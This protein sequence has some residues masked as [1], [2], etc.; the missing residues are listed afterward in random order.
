[1]TRFEK[2]LMALQAANVDWNAK[3]QKVSLQAFADGK[4]DKTDIEY[5]LECLNRAA[6]ACENIN[7]QNQ[8]TD[9]SV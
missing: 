9:K 7:L 5:I 8:V 6:L 2:F 1:M 3:M 4:L